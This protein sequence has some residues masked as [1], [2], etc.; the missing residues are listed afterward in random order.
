MKKAISN[1]IFSLSKV[2]DNEEENLLGK[3]KNN[4]VREK[5][6]REQKVGEEAEPNSRRQHWQKCDK[7]IPEYILK[8]MEYEYYISIFEEIYIWGNLWV[9]LGWKFRSQ[10][11]SWFADHMFLVEINEME[12]LNRLRKIFE[13]RDLQALAQLVLKNLDWFES[14][15]KLWLYSEKFVLPVTLKRFAGEE[16]EETGGQKSGKEVEETGGQESGKEV[17][18]TAGQEEHT[19]GETQ[20]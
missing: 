14:E 8:D 9:L 17:E 12:R 5:V 7:R 1:P 11:L 6:D 20:T 16:I 3:K 19:H 18:E 15:E 13:N 10:H 4:S 2:R